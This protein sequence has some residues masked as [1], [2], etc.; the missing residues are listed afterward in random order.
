MTATRKIVVLSLA[1][2]VLGVLA[3]L[4]FK[5]TRA[6]GPILGA[7]FGVASIWVVWSVLV[8][9][10]TQEAATIGAIVFAFV[11]ATVALTVSLHDRPVRAGSAGLFLGLGAGGGASE[12]ADAWR[13]G[14][15]PERR[16]QETLFNARPLGTHG[17]RR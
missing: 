2:P 15:R 3:D 5:P 8:Q 11:L 4:A 7:L 6:T 9:K 12:Y 10:S 17:P 1:A 16:V 13:C 14:K